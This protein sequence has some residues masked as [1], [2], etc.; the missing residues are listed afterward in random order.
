M[1][2]SKMSHSHVSPRSTKKKWVSW[3]ISL[4]I[5]IILIIVGGSILH[6]SAI[7]KTSTS[8]KIVSNNEVEIR[9]TA[10]TEGN[11]AI[12][13]GGGSASNHT[14]THQYVQRIPADSVHHLTVTVTPLPA[15]TA[16]TVAC[17]IYQ[18]GHSVSS[19]SGSGATA[20]ATCSLN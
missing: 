9:A 15:G 6:H 16:G 14:F 4:A 7:Q 8:I 17:T 2:R 3:L 10:S 19:Q 18:N 11:I 13:N 1:K 20:T 5:V 12:M